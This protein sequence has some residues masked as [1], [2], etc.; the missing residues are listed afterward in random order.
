MVGKRGK[1]REFVSA[2]TR[3]R[4]VVYVKIQ[5]RELKKVAG[6]TMC[7]RF[8]I[9]HDSPLVISMGGFDYESL[10]AG[11]WVNIFDGAAW[12]NNSINCNAR[13]SYWKILNRTALG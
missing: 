13:V 11:N 3:E 12:N 2:C 10:R 4:R 1:R 8:I 9:E 7:E 6:K 5:T